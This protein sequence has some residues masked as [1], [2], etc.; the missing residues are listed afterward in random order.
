MAKV[1]MLE[2]GLLIFFCPG[3]GYD[4]PYHV[5]PQC[6]EA[7]A[8]GSHAPLWTWNGSFDAPTLNPSL[9]VFGMVPEKRCHIFMRDGKIQFLSDCFH[10][11]KGQT[12]ECPEYEI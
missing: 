6:R 2:P 10:R 12:I 7:R 3:C 4:H 9:L 1:Y 5:G 8:D 11:L